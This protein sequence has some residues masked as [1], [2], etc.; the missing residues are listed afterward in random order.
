MRPILI[1]ATYRL[2]APPPQKSEVGSASAGPTSAFGI[3]RDPARG[4]SH[5]RSRHGFPAS[6]PGFAPPP[7]RLRARP[8]GPRH[9]APTSGPTAPTSRAGNPDAPRAAE[10]SG[11][12]GAKRSRPGGRLH[13]SPLNHR[14]IP[15]AP[16]RG[17]VATGCCDSVIVTN[18]SKRKRQN[19][20][21]N[22]ESAC[23]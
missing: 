9:A 16:A 11:S 1:S 15:G 12:L 2:A 7:P 5:P 4:I 8:P 6:R 21:E 13:L 3:D 10:P 17:A 23:S 22:A 14:K 19:A 18:A 20:P